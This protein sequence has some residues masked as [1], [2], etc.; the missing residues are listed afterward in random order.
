MCQIGVYY[1]SIRERLDINFFV[2]FRILAPIFHISVIFDVRFKNGEDIQ[3][4]ENITAE[5]SN[6]Y[7]KTIFHF[8]TCKYF[9][10]AIDIVIKNVTM[11]GFCDYFLLILE[12]RLIA[13]SVI[14]FSIT[15]T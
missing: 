14:N 15:F 5:E 1:R 9:N 8:E 13:E 3:S 4:I 7:F 10:S 11:N 2:M 6:S 12:W